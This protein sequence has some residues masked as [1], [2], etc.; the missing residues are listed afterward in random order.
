VEIFKS[1]DDSYLSYL[2]TERMVS[3]NEHDDGT[4]FCR[5]I[6]DLKI[7][8]FNVGIA[9][10]IASYGRLRLA[11]CINALRKV[12]GS[13]YYCDTDS[14]ICDINLND[15][16]ELKEEFQWDGKGEE[17]GT[18]KNECH[19]E[20]E[21]ILKKMY[22][23]KDPVIKV[24]YPE[25][26]LKRETLLHDKMKEENGNM[27]FD[28]VILT[29]CKQYALKKDDV[30]VEGNLKSLEICKL[31]GYSKKGKKLTYNDFKMLD[32]G[33]L[34]KQKQMQFHCPKSNYV[35]ETEQFTIKTEYVNKC[36]R[37]TYSKGV[38]ESDKTISPLKI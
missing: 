23:D 26:R 3:M 4:M 13:V 29:G 25:N 7:K 28:S 19:D 9:S 20:F 14:I 1:N 17:L 30:D 16:P 18:L 33:E 31:K 38:V 2:N 36:F 11:S 32:K 5:V 10:A 15:Y 21:N 37:Q 34:I 12:G 24:E 8:D 27:H 22:P 6:K 35:S